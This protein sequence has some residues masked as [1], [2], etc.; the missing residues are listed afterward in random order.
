MESEL[1]SSISP[2]SYVMSCVVFQKST[3]PCLYIFIIQS[4]PFIIFKDSSCLFKT[5]M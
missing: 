4:T 1:K 2:G 5:W 3:S